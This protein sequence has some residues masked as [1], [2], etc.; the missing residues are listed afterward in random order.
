MPCAAAKLIVGKRLFAR[1]EPERGGLQ[2][3]VPVAR[4]CADGAI[5]FVGTERQIDVCFEPDGT[6]MAA[7]RVCLEHFGPLLHGPG[8]TIVHQVELF[9]N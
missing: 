2:D 3:Y 9:Q 4:L 8:T 6:T 7:S 5:T 1:Q